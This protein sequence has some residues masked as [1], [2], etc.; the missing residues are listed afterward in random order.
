MTGKLT[1]SSFFSIKNDEEIFILSRYSCQTET[2]EQFEWKYQAKTKIN[3]P[4]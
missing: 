2:K 4:L 1:P 3:T